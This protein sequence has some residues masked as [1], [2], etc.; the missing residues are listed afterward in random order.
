MGVN[1]GGV[2]RKTDVAEQGAEGVQENATVLQCYRS[3]SDS[4]D[5]SSDVEEHIVNCTAVAVGCVSLACEHDT[6][7]NATRAST[8]VGFVMVID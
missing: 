1:G 3:F 6:R 8:Y 4:E 5:P 2:L 7:A